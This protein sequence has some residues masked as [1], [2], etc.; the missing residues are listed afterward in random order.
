MSAA[1]PA[2]EPRPKST[3]KT[4][5]VLGGVVLAYS[6]V[7]AMLVPAL[8]LIQ[9]GI[10]A[11]PS[12]ITWV[13]TG[14]LLSGT[15]CTPLIGRLAD[16]HE[17]KVVFLVVVTVVALG[18]FLAAIAT[19]IVELAIGQ[20]L[21]G[22]GMGLFPLTL[23]FLREI[24][25]AHKARTGTGLIVGMS[26]LGSISGGLLAGPLLKVLPYNWLYWLPLGMIVI[27]TV[28][29]R[30]SLPSIPSGE[31]GSVDWA[32]AV[33]LSTGLFTMLIGLTQAPTWG[34]SSLKF[35]GLA[36]L[37]ASLLTAFTVL[38]LEIER[39]LVDLRSGGKTVGVICAIAFAVGWV[40]FT[41][42]LSIPT[43][44]ASPSS[45]GYGL[46]GT[47]TLAGLVLLPM[48][49]IGAVSALLAG[50]LERKVCAKPLMVLSS[51]P[52]MAS[53]AILLLARH[54]LIMLVFA[55]GLL[56]LGIG[57][58]LTQAM[59]VV[60]SAVPAERVASATGFVMVMRSVGSTLGAQVSGTVLASELIPGTPL[61]AW[62][63]F[64]AI[65]VI[66]TV[67]GL[68]SIAASFAL[69]RRIS[70]PETR[71]SASA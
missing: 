31:R 42:Y 36:A 29:G 25:P 7:E 15:V 49:L 13:F 44:V 4:L 71:I 58:G 11:S 40:T 67:V 64:T 5:I 56:G 34:W 35:L 69:P 27:L 63:S 46:G 53:S 12:S 1:A 33:L 2:I 59:N 39:P 47:P 38:E 57:L 32:G 28:M 24:L 65:F 37:S 9:H 41:V 60:S 22:T 70:T 55:A 30:R 8:P 45:A 62:S 51:V 66:A 68:T 61:P 26:A 54:E 10:G 52:I 3:T 6:L 17:K 48:G 14:L 23:G 16:I 50:P 18:I 43:I 21:Q 20:I 19:S